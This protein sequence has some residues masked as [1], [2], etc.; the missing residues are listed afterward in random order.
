MGIIQSFMYMQR[1]GTPVDNPVWDLW[2][3][4]LEDWLIEKANIEQAE[5]LAELTGLRF[6]VVLETGEVIYDSYLGIKVEYTFMGRK[7]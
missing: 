7:T 6:R 3:R 1:P 4:N 5:R 2:T